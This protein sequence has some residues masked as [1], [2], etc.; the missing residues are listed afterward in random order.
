MDAW[1]RLSSRDIVRDRWMRLRAD[2]C[3]IA[4]GKVIEP[5]YVVEEPD[6]VHAVVFDDTQRVLLVRQ[7]RYAADTIAYELPGGGA[8]SDEDPLAAMQRE[9]REETGCAAEAWRYLGAS[10]PNPARQNNRVHCF[11]AERAHV[12]AQPRF[13]ETEDISVHF[14]PVPEVL[15]LMRNGGINQA[16]HIGL[17]H[18]ALI[19]LGFLA[20][21]L[22][23]R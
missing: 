16:M 13:D 11:V 6:W 2:R 18:L 14:L 7:Y 15:Q 12:V 8:H 4:P 19:E 1:K 10:F 9:L 23:P 20:E 3:E 21:N 17:L 5:Y 22:P